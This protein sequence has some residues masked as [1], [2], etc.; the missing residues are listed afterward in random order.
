[1]MQ[2]VDMER[3]L[4]QLDN[5]VQSIY[6]MLAGISASVARWGNRLEE[7]DAKL[8]AVD[9]KLDTRLNAVDAR[10][11]TIVRLLGGQGTD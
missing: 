5:D 7:L 3:K 2:P 8:D 1:M 11:D 10:L 6:E 9:V 4:R